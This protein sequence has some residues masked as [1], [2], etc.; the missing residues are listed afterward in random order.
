MQCSPYNRSKL[1][2]SASTPHA[3]CFFKDQLLAIARSLKIPN[4]TTKTSKQAMWDAINRAMYNRH[5]CADGDEY[6]WV[7]RHTEAA[8]YE[9]SFLPLQPSEWKQ[10]PS[11]WLSNFDILNVINQYE[12]SNPSFKF[13]GVFP[14]NFGQRD[15]VGR[16]ISEALCNIQLSKMKKKHRSFG[17]V[18]NLDRHD[19][20]GSH[21]VC[22]FFSLSEP[23]YGFYYFD[24]NAVSMPAQIR[25][26]ARSMCRQVEDKAFKIH[27]NKKRK[28]FENNECGMFCIH[29]IIQCINKVPFKQIVNSPFY[30]KD[31][32]AMRKE[33]FRQ[34]TGR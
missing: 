33:V 16:C 8:K 6:C 3:S 14:I 17:A 5:N 7:D 25:E 23:N 28:Q 15:A 34:Q 31:A 30:D 29:F 24:S 19:Q 1:R 2:G 4:I 10:N 18:F 26:F 13:F 12:Q 32:N 11:T 21:W 22:V 27:E 20:P 9:K